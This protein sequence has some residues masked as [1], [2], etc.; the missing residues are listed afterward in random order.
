MFKKNKA[1]TLIELIIVVAIIGIMA[2]FAIP[3]YM[4]Y[5]KQSALSQKAEEMK[6]LVDLT[7]HLSQNPENGQVESYKLSI[8]F[9]NSSHPND[10][11]HN[12]ILLDRIV[13]GNST[14]VRRVEIAKSQGLNSSSTA[15]PIEIICSTD[16]SVGCTNLTGFTSPAAGGGYNIFQLIY[17]SNIQNINLKLDP[18]ATKISKSVES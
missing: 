6:Q 9:D 1:Y 15:S 17:G 4:E 10:P 13:G 14:N 11:Q 8:F 16:K 18:F 12:Y 2:V 5:G 7:Y 3:A